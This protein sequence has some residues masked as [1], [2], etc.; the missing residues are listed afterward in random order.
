MH[1]PIFFSLSSLGVAQYRDSTAMHLPIAVLFQAVTT[2]SQSTS[3]VKCRGLFY[4]RACAGSHTCIHAHAGSDIA[5]NREDRGTSRH[6]HDNTQGRWGSCVD[7]P[8]PP[9]RKLSYAPF[10]P[11]SPF[12]K[13]EGETVSHVLKH[14][15]DYC[16]WFAR[17]V[18]A[19]TEECEEVIAEIQAKPSRTVEETG[20][21]RSSFRSGQRC[22][23]P[24]MPVA[25]TLT[26]RVG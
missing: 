16:R 1:Y 23:P 3:A 9:E 17:N 20:H 8:H 11:Q 12:A 4:T 19:E 21:Q 14:D 15:P 6:C 10:E 2:A 7:L 13:Y 24:G 26:G 25:A 5:H 18:G 22:M